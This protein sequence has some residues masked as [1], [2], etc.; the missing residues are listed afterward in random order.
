MNFK[1]GS[2]SV[3]SSVT[4]MKSLKKHILTVLYLSSYIKYCMRRAEQQ[5][6]RVPDMDL[7]RLGLHLD[8]DYPRLYGRWMKDSLLIHA[9]RQCE[10][11]FRPGF[12]VLGNEV[13]VRQLGFRSTRRTGF[14][15]TAVTDIVSAGF[16]TGRGKNSLDQPDCPDQAEQV[17]GSVRQER[18]RPTERRS[19][20]PQT[21]ERCRGRRARLS[22]QILQQ[23]R[24]FSRAIRNLR[25]D[26]PGQPQGWPGFNYSG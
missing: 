14:A 13:L 18:C 11:Y 19:R 15:H 7:Q 21:R 24:R 2:R 3:K 26:P 9:N 25:A 4:A 23:G 20:Q 1:L 16:V 17:T 8:P 12:S 22:R 5:S 10:V 6:E